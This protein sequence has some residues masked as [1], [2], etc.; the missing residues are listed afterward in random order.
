MI[1]KEIYLYP[2]TLDYDDSFTF[3]FKLQTR[4][5]CNYIER[6]IKNL[7]YKTPDFK[8]VCFICRDGI[9][10]ESYVN[11]CNV[12]CV[13]ILINKNEY[14]NLNKFQL[15][16]Y[17]ISL[18]LA[19][20]DKCHGKYSLPN[21][22]IVEAI[23]SFRD[24]NYVNEWVFK[25]KKINKTKLECL[26]KCHLTMDEFSFDLQVKDRGAVVFEDNII[27]DKPN[28]F[29]FNYYLKDLVIDDEIKVYGKNNK[30]LYSKNI[31]EI[32]NKVMA[33]K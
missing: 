32:I 11:S 3:P 21:E 27:K 1:L 19:G 30:I 29:V 14:L 9:I 13:N 2:E 4:S 12:L 22:K 15:N 7:K 16:E 20:L 10:D 17:F 25:K 5:L 8:R 31:T 18:L 24:L 23:N 26:L 33:S 6:Y 28:E